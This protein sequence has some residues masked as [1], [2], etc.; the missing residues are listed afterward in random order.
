MQ[1]RLRTCV[2]LTLAMT[3]LAMTRCGVALANPVPP[4]YEDFPVAPSEFVSQ[5]TTPLIADDFE[6]AF[7]G[8]IAFVEWWGSLSAGPWQ[9]TL[10]DN[11]DADPATPDDGGSSV[12]V[13]PFSVQQWNSDIFYYAADVS[14][15]GWRLTKR[16]P[17]WLSVASVEPGWTWAL[18]DGQPEFGWQ[19]Q[20]AVGS[21]AAGQWA[22]LEPPSDLAFGVWPTLVSEPGD[23]VLVLIGVLGLGPTLAARTTL[24]TAT[25]GS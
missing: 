14:S 22:S 2:F 21:A 9:V 15:A 3:G 20:F 13:E 4:G 17:Y 8:V 11:A 12:F 24:V 18:G 10:Y 19:R 23:W 16:D 7:S 6:P 5:V 25:L 1:G